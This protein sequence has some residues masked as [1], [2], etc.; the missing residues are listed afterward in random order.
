M[1]APTGVSPVAVTGAGATLQH[2]P[3]HLG[4]RV[5]PGLRT[6]R[7]D[8]CRDRAARFEVLRMVPGDSPA[9]APASPVP[10]WPFPNPPRTTARPRWPAAGCSTSRA[11]ARRSERQY[12]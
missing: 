7:T 2:P 12:W 3:H 8:G 1:P 9:A 6:L 5:H 11:G 4:Y 10:N